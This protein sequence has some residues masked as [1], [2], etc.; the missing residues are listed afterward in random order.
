MS[1]PAARPLGRY[2]VRL[3][4]VG[5]DGADAAV[6][7]L[8]P[9]VFT[10]CASKLARWLDSEVSWLLYSESSVLALTRSAD[11]RG[12]LLIRVVSFV[13]LSCSALTCRWSPESCAPIAALW[14]L[15]RF[16]R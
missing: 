5:L 14:L 11:P 7:I 1:S 13:I 12:I 10:D 9:V 4:L 6:M 15:L 8:P 16:C 3:G 2:S